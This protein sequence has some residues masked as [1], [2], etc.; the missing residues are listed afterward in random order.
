LTSKV[1][2]LEEVSEQW[3]ERCQLLEEKLTKAASYIRELS[4]ENENLVK[5][6]EDITEKL[7]ARFDTK[8]Q[9]TSS[10]AFIQQLETLIQNNGLLENVST[11]K[12]VKMMPVLQKLSMILTERNQLLSGNIFKLLLYQFLAV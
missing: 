8:I 5:D 7:S 1:L 4:I 11:I 6:N 10:E 2:R 12:D 9:E 3:R